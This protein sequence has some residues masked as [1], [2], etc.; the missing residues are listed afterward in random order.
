MELLVA[1]S[2]KC[3]LWMQ[4]V[5][6]KQWGLFH[7]PAPAGSDRYQIS[8]LVQRSFLEEFSDVKSAG[9][10][11]QLGLRLSSGFQGRHYENSSAKPVGTPQ[12]LMSP[13]HSHLA[14]SGWCTL[15]VLLP[16]H[17]NFNFQ[18]PHSLSF[19]DFRPLKS[20]RC[21]YW[22][23]KLFIWGRQTKSKYKNNP[24]YLVKVLSD[25]SL[26]K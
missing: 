16:F 19:T 9:A 23:T 26:W 5:Q 25:I 14:L 3:G 4:I 1:L 15:T 20:T 13:G 10:Q 24:A 8:D 17:K 11:G 2:C 18:C 21:E 22:Q 12:T 6:I 7:G